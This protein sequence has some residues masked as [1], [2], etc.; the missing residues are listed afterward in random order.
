[1]DTMM[2][3][4]VGEISLAQE[5]RNFENTL[6]FFTSDNGAAKRLTAYTIHAEACRERSDLQRGR[7]PGAHDCPVAWKNQ[8]RAVSDHPWYFP[9]VMPT[10]AEIAGVSDE[11]PDDIDGISVCQRC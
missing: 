4:Q 1:M 7:H 3:R 6:M 11:A 9:D 2:D 10:L 8:T 5:T